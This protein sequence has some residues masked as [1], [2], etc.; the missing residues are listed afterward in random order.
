MSL[1]FFS[2][3]PESSREGRL[4]SL[5]CCVGVIASGAPVQAFEGYSDPVRPPAASDLSSVPAVS[6]FHIPTRLK[7]IE[8]EIGMEAAALAVLAPFQ[9]TVQ[10]D[11][12]GY[13]SD[14][15]PA[16]AG[17]P[18][19]PL[20]TLDFDT[21]GNKSSFGLVMVPAVDQRSPERKGYAFPKRFRVRA[22][23][24]N[25]PGVIYVDWTAQDFPDPGRRP[26]YF[27]L[28]GQSSPRVRLEVFSG[29]QENGLEFFALARLNM[30]RRNEPQNITG[31]AASSSFESPP[32]WSQNYLVSERYTLGMP[33]A[34]KSGEDG[35]LTL[36]LPASR[37]DQPLTIRVELGKQEPLGWVNLFPGQSPDRID[38]PG[39]GFPGTMALY[40]IVESEDGRRVTCSLLPDQDRVKN[41]GHNLLRLPGKNLRLSVLLVECNDFPVYQGQAV[42]SLGEIEVFKAGR[43][44]SRDHR[45]TIHGVSPKEA[46]DWTTLV[47]GRV[48]GRNILHLTDWLQQLAAGKPHEARL[49]TLQAE[50][51]SLE[52][53]WSHFIR[54]VLMGSGVLG[55]IGGGLLVA[56]M[57]RIRSQATM[58]LRRQ[59]NSDLHDDIGSKIAAISL[60]VSDVA[61]HASEEHIR[62]R[63]RWVGSVVN[64][65]HQGLR[66]VL[67]LTNDKT[68]SLALLVQKL[69]ETARQQVPEQKLTLRLSDPDSIPDKSI[70]LQTKRDIL[71]FTKEALHNAIAHA[72]SNQISVRVTVEKRILILRI[73]DDGVG[74]E[75]PS[76]AQADRSVEHLGLRTMRERAN[77][78]HGQLRLSSSPGSG[79]VVELT[80]RM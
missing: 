8:T 18:D 26:V 62:N 72:E 45:I 77:R 66:D 73:V 47:D 78:L 34:E 76:P 56:L 44:L 9:D 25:Q 61:L 33:L 4:R 2:S 3:I 38:V 63:G 5:L 50:Q 40:A 27:D 79:T 53:R 46:V 75:V 65:M 29:H 74:F 30:I 70:G 12:F 20:W 64:T 14:Y 48:S 7:E 1:S 11:Q 17:V 41:P 36:K 58:Q 35:D 54:G 19:E 24:G 21:G 16:V 49:K 31:V 32:Y 59:I 22:L 51:M 15:L 55:L 80:V 71:F 6:L 10:F 42:F 67:W 43:N 13:H 52:G 69:A 37:L 28:S 39:Y 68:D 23:N 57:W 60:A